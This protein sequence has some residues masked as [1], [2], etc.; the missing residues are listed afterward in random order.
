VNFNIN[1]NPPHHDIII[2]GVVGAGANGV[3]RTDD[4]SNV[5]FTNSLSGLAY[6]GG[7]SAIRPFDDVSTLQTNVNVG[8]CNGNIHCAVKLT[9]LGLQ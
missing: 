9:Q 7:V 1:V 6:P 8:G 2:S 5:S 3:L 4:I